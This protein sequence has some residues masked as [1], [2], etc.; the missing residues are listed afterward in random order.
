MTVYLE[1]GYNR[2]EY[3]WFYKQYQNIYSKEIFMIYVGIDVAKDK[4]D[5]FI[6]NSDG[7]ILYNAFTIQNN[8]EGFDELYQKIL[9]VEVDMSNIKVGLEATGHYNYNLLG[10]L[11]DKGL[12]TYV[13]NPLH[14]NLYRMMLY[15]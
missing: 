7:E 11:I 14:T 6:S 12:P 13:I 8:R 1:R 9:F 10:Y 2:K 5:C 3:Q 15:K 4:H